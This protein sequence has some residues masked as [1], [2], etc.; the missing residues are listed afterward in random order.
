MS[1]FFHAAT[2]SALAFVIFQT[3]L[4]G[5]SL[6]ATQAQVDALTAQVVKVRGEIQVIKTEVVNLKDQLANAETVEEIDLSALESAVQAADDENVDVVPVVAPEV[7]VEPEADEDEDE[8]EDV[9]TEPVA[10]DE[11]VI[12]DAAPVE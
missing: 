5:R 9:A 12:E 8:D 11:P 6:M 3:T 1:Y 10:V 7:E 2:L 4:I